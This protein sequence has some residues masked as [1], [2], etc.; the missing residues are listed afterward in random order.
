MKIVLSILII[1]LTFSIPAHSRL[2][3]STVSPNSIIKQLEVGED[4]TYVVKYAFFNL[5]E[6]RFKI[7]GKDIINGITVFKTV[8]Y[9]DS[10]EGL[11]FVT[12]HQV[13][14]S[15]IDSSYFPL[16][17]L[18]TM[19]DDDTTYT[20]YSFVGDSIRHVV[21]GN[22]NTKQ[23][24]VD[25]SI[26]VNKVF[27]DGLSI[28]YFA[29]MN[30]GR[31]TTLFVPCFVNERQEIAILNFHSENEEIE[32]DA[33]DYEIDCLRLDG[34]TNFVSVYGFTGEFEGCFSNDMYSIPIVASM[35]VLI[36]H[37]TLELI[38]WNLKDWNPPEY[39]D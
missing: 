27:Q 8:A 33:V 15:F 23:V 28:L 35:N 16:S 36:G 3:D 31:D 14:E 17:F 18:G 5:G 24:S 2:A 7:V 22:P 9:I 37:V 6:I 32:I 11:P 12:I 10:Y 38:S 19:L 29:R 13:Y 26:N 34:S 39:K 25:S 20:E 30:T 1:F 4:L 21:K